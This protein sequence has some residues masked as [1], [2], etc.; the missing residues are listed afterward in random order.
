MSQ[1]SRPNGLSADLADLAGRRDALRQ[2]AAMAG[3]DPDALLDAAFTEL[4]A[5][6]EVLTKLIQAAAGEPDRPAG[7][8]L[9]VSL[10]AERSLLRAVFQHAPAPLFV[11]EPDGTIRRANGR[12]GDENEVILAGDYEDRFVTAK[13][14]YLRWDG[15]HV[16]VELAS[17][18]HPGP[19]VVRADGRV[20]VLSGGGLPL[21]LFPDAEPERETLELGQDDLL[22]FYSDG[23]TEARSPDMQYFEDRLADELAGT[24]GQSAAETARMVQG[25]VTRFTQDDLRDDMTILVAKVTSPP[26][27][28]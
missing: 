7:E 19:A 14:A 2:A 24:A 22:F 11:L 16:R 25:L 15:D 26:G 4:D 3:A 6:V 12:A 1:G 20:D 13:L 9:P 17:S 5:A 21:G 18:G 10:S 28:S 27:T 8:A 23:V